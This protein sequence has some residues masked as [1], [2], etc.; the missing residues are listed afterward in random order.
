M[1]HLQSV[2]L[3]VVVRYINSIDTLSKFSCI[4]SKCYDV[5]NIIKVNPFLC[6]SS[7]EYSLFNNLQRCIQFQKELK[8]FSS[9]Q[10]ITIDSTLIPY[11]K[12]TLHKYLLRIT[13]C[14][15]TLLFQL[16]KLY[17]NITELTITVTTP[18]N[19]PNFSQY[20]LLRKLR[21]QFEC[22]IPN[23]G[24]LFPFLLQHIYYLFIQTQHID[25]HFLTTLHLRNFDKVV[26]LTNKKNIIKLS[27]IQNIFTSMTLCCDE[28]SDI[29][30]NKVIILHKTI[31]QWI[32]Q[33]KCL[34]VYMK[35]YYPS[36]LNVLTDCYTNQI[37]DLSQYPQIKKMLYS[38]EDYKVPNTPIKNL[39]LKSFDG[40]LVL[41]QRTTKLKLI[42]SDILNFNTTTQLKCL[43][44]EESSIKQDLINFC[45]LSKLTLTFCHFEQSVQFPRNVN[46]ISIDNCSVTSSSHV[47]YSNVLNS[48]SII[49]SD[50]F[51]TNLPLSLTYLMLYDTKVIPNLTHY[52]SLKFLKLC[53]IN[54]FDQ[55]LPQSL[56]QLI[57]FNI[58]CDLDVSMCTCLQ[59]LGISDCQ[60]ISIVL[61]SMVK[62]LMIEN[63]DIEINNKKKITIEELYIDFTKQFLPQQNQI[64]SILDTTQHYQIFER[65]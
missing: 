33:N 15:V 10:T 29:F 16:S 58:H 50:N 3:A 6:C 12:Q 7:D 32:T 36:S 43:H 28:W 14:D 59:L 57:L 37:I 27:S 49:S 46:V 64:H 38:I 21:I 41:S 45:S 31:P 24:K 61:P 20:P 1:L 11:L 8:I 17:N 26:V 23:W 56:T 34:D 48:L 53:G 65:T 9:I 4:N 40:D 42:N 18:T 62:C 19:M 63:T 44:L 55:P 35:L 2:Y 22:E 51:I 5:M 25:L 13:S 54:I 39:T 47:L 30:D 52:S 60:H